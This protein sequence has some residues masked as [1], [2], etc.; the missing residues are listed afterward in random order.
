M[1]IFTIS[2]SK[3]LILLLAIFIVGYTTFGSVSFKTLDDLRIQGNLYNQIVMSKDLIADVLPPPGYIIESYLNVLQMVDETDPAQMDY[4]FKE[5]RRLQTN[6]EERHKFWRNEPLLEQGALRDAMLKGAYEPAVRFYDIVFSKFIP[7]LQNGNREYARELVQSE[8]KTMYAEH[9]KSVDQVVLGATEKYE[10]VENLANAKIQKDTKLLFTIAIVVIIA[11]LI[12]SLAIRYSIVK[13]IVRV[14]NVLKDI[15]EAEGDLTRTIAVNSK[16]EVGHLALYFNKTLEKIK[17]LIV[18]VKNQT[19]SLA[20]VSEELSSVSRQVANSAEANI[21][22]ATT[23]ASAS[24]QASANI[25]SIAN[26]AEKTSANANDVAGSAE[27][28][29]ANMYTIA[30]AIEQMSASISE[31][32]SNA[33]EVSKIANEATIKS[34]DATDVMSKLG[35]AAKEIGHVTDVIKKIADKTNLLA[36]NATIEA[37]SA[38][39]AGKGFAVVA[40]EIKE[41]ANQSASSADDIAQRIDSIQVGTDEAVKVINDVSDII[42]KINHSVESIS[43]HVGEQTKA[44]NEI[45]S[46]VAQANTGAKRVASAISEVAKNSHDVARNADEAAKGASEVS[47]SVSNITQDTKNSALG[48]KQTNQSADELAKIANDLVKVLGQFKV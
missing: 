5:L 9:R 12:L 46:N 2:I 31:I 35:V 28:M 44:S 40:G 26:N 18:A 14:T 22:N 32:S 36:L 27:Q 34:H 24:E 16:D 3:K 8:L 11:A 45:A 41:L 4:F 13:P 30:A 43:S 1:N 6:Y 10:K 15:S 23:V 25:I 21:S 37:A 7:A 47:K 48:A 42:A 39:E 29:S 17:K 19:E 38:G 33:G 20:S